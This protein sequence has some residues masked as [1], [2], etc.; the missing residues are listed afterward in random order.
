LKLAESLAERPSKQVIRILVGCGISASVSNR[1]TVIAPDL[2]FTRDGKDPVALNLK[3]AQ[4]MIAELLNVREVKAHLAEVLG[5]EGSDGWKDPNL[6]MDRLI[7]TMNRSNAERIFAAMTLACQAYRFE[8][9]S[10]P[11]S[12]EQLVPNYLPRL[13]VDPWGDGKQ[14]YGYVLIKGGLPGSGDR[15]LVYSRCGAE[16]GLAYRLDEP[17]YGYYVG[18]G[19]KEGQKWRGGQFRDVARWEPAAIAPGAARTKALEKQ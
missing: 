7:E 15:P 11:T 10:W 19:T 17:Q 9:G 8:N 4:E 12:A 3:N 2:K 5:P 14:T 6:K 16:T 1:I 18:D 13:P